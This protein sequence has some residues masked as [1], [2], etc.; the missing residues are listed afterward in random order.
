[1]GNQTLIGHDEHIGSV[2]TIG[3]PVEDGMVFFNSFVFSSKAFEIADSGSLYNGSYL[4]DRHKRVW[5]EVRRVNWDSFMVFF[6]DG[7]KALLSQCVFPIGHGAIITEPTVL[8]L[9]GFRSPLSAGEYY[10]LKA[11]PKDGFVEIEGFSE[12]FAVPRFDIII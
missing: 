10:K 2:F 8:C 9:D 4:Y 7:T 12:Y 6:K 11:P 3:P 5:K 1:L